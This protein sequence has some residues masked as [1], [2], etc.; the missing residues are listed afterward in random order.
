[1]RDLCT[2]AVARLWVHEHPSD[3]TNSALALTDVLEQN[4]YSRTEM[5][6]LKAIYSII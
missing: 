4:W 5:D 2:Y 1:M 3:W 6:T